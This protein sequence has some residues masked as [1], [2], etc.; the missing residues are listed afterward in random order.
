VCTS[1]GTE[2]VDALLPLA[3]SLSVIADVTFAT[4]LRQAL[5]GLWRQKR[6]T[7]VVVLTLGIA[8][9]ANIAVFHVVNLTLL[10]PLPF[11]EAEE[12]FRVQAGVTRPNGAT[13]L[14]ALSPHAFVRIR[15]AR[16]FEDVVA[17][18]L[19]NL[20]IRTATGE[21]QRVAAVRV[22]SGWMELFGLRPAL[23]RGFTEHE[24]RLGAG[25]P[26]VLISHS[27]WQ[28][29]FGGDRGVLGRSILLEDHALTV[30]GVMP[31]SFNYP[32][33]SELW[34]PMTV[35]R[36]LTSPT[37]LNVV[38]RLRHGET[39]DAARARLRALSAQLARETAQPDGERVLQ[40][41]P[42]RTD[43]LEN[44]DRVLI[45]LLAAVAF[46]LLIA[47]TNVASLTLTRAV[48]RRRE[49]A[50]R[51]ALGATRLRRFGAIVSETVVLAALGGALGALL[52]SWALSV[53]SV[54]LPRQLRE[55][56]AQAALDER[57]FAFVA[58]VTVLAGFIFGVLPAFRLSGSPQLEQLGSGLRTTSTKQD[59]GLLSSVVVAEIA[60]A[61]L[62]A[63]GAAQMLQ[64]VRDSETT[65]PGFDVENALTL[66]V[67]L[68]DTRFPT[69]QAR[70]AF[71]GRIAEVLGSMPGVSAVG[72]TSML[73]VGGGNQLAQVSVESR[74][75]EAVAFTV[76]HRVIDA[77]YF[78]AMGIPLLAGRRFDDRDRTGGEPVAIVSRALAD[79]SW[80]GADPVGKRIRR[81]RAAGQTPWL[82]VVGV[83]G[84]VR[85]PREAASE[86]WYLPYTQQVATFTG[87]I[88]PVFVL[89]AAL[90]PAVLGDA[91]RLMVA[92][93]DGA[94]PVF[95]V[96]TL[97]ELNTL[98][99]AQER[100][101]TEVMA[102]FAIA[103]L[104]LVLLGV[105]GVTSYGVSQR[106][107]EIG[108][109][110]AFGAPSRQIVRMVLA[111]TATL[112][113]MGLT[114]GTA[115]AMLAVRGLHRLVPG[116][117]PGQW[118]LYAVPAAG[119]AAVTLLAG[120][121]PAWRATRIDA[122]RALQDR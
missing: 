93:V 23:G 7:A 122:A 95:Q 55:L 82:T 36:G 58:A 27:L 38:G 86:S 37:N 49:M 112:S 59:R 113:A 103:G 106:V 21:P 66:R 18:R 8:I 48:N 61:L 17:Q 11:D 98:Q 70:L 102:A 109:R 107:Q 73:P 99:F 22:A 75:G 114:I 1:H 92:R 100:L 14:V 19:E 74:S 116:I 117:D 65:H 12:L 24:E 31:P 52:A 115:G 13:S 63:V 111:Q 16:I 64:Y 110:I 20:A 88:Q 69:A 42:L 101:G 97:K 43:L 6:F 80:P 41:T 54:L 81:T 104:L 120:A 45:A 3:S 32:Y 56:G 91:A 78:K 67:P 121:L 87:F 108:I 46:V 79:R 5:R 77:G 15:E 105:Y 84:N 90:E 96:A 76:N 9:G 51:T 47:A 25:A 50:V 68:S 29:A 62:L 39:A 72:L 83:V 44:N 71:I 60:L 94:T 4:D 85:E 118:I 2:Q 57:M 34:L 30:V 53:V 119:L 10:R 89:K 26:A 28:R 33:Q 35:D 40:A